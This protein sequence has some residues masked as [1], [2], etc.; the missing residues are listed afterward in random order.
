M[1][2]WQVLNKNCTICSIF[3]NLFWRKTMKLWAKLIKNEK[4]IQHGTVEAENLNTFS[5]IT[6]GL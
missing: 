4:I 1:Q 5:G 3:N 2:N 6:K